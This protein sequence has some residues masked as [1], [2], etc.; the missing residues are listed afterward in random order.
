VYIT[1]NEQGNMSLM[2]D[3]IHKKINFICC[4]SFG[5]IDKAFIDYY[6]NQTGPF[7]DKIQELNIDIKHKE[8]IV[9]KNITIIEEFNKK[10]KSHDILDFM[11]YGDHANHT[12]AK[13]EISMYKPDMI[14]S[15]VLRKHILKG[16]H[17]GFTYER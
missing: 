5:D 13:A 1:K 12:R 6:T 7:F 10:M 11:S 3:S 4:H 17:E 2:E 16:L 8:T 15:I 14:I 9:E